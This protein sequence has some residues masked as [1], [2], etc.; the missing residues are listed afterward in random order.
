MLY[1]V[2][3]VSALFRGTLLLGC[4]R[5]VE[6]GAACR[7]VSPSLQ[8]TDS[9]S[10]PWLADALVEMT[11]VVQD[12]TQGLNYAGCSVFM[13]DG[14]CKRCPLLTTDEGESLVS[15]WRCAARLSGGGFVRGCSPPEDGARAHTHTH[16]CKGPHAGPSAG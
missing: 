11:G 14:E 1:S 12:V 7:T 6:L 15:L 10:A 3:L 13:A 2:A 9:P 4:Q 16:T 5:G 8:D